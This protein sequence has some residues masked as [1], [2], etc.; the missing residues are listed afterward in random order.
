MCGIFFSLGSKGFIHPEEDTQCIIRNRG[1][2][3]YQAH[4]VCLPQHGTAGDSGRKRYLT[5]IS[6]VLALRGDH[7]ETQPS[8]DATSQSVLCWNGEAW[9]ISGKTVTGNDTHQIFQLFL[10]SVKP[11]VDS[12]A[13]E[14][15]TGQSSL[16]TLAHTISRISGPFSFVFY[17]GFGSRIIYGRDFLGRRS[18]LSGWDS[19]GNLKI[20][21]VCDGT[22]SNCFEEVT[23]D[24]IHVIDLSC[25]VRV[26]DPFPQP[27]TIPWVRG[28][29]SLTTYLVR[30]LP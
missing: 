11:P 12:D 30:L 14:T 24:G 19:E 18:L 29:T 7:T 25:D 20:S 17:D 9:K 1:P 28:E 26:E 2:D 16:N 22:S 27:D 5:F 23:T 13:L 15:P 6:S 4:E 10:E 21:S 8:I 3:S